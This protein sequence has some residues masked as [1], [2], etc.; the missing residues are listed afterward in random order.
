M[1]LGL[2]TTHRQKRTF[3]ST[4]TRHWADL[5]TVRSVAHLVVHGWNKCLD[6]LRDDSTRPTTTVSVAG[7]Y[8]RL[9]TPSPTLQA[10]SS[11][12]TWKYVNEG[13]PVHESVGVLDKDIWCSQSQQLPRYAYI[14]STFV[15]KTVML[16]VGAHTHDD[17]EVLSKVPV[18]D[19]LVV[20]TD[21]EKPVTLEISVRSLLQ[22]SGAT[23]QQL[24]PSCATRMIRVTRIQCCN[25]SSRVHW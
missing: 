11:T 1:W 6:Q 17:D 20:D 12:V 3:S 22:Y 9:W 8:S 21:K 13:P 4:S 18:S 2:T 16:Q 10:S 15:L 5:L 25:W 23:M 7:R 19:V 14:M 24:V